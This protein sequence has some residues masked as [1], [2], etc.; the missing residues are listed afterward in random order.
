ME[1]MPARALDINITPPPSATLGNVHLFTI[2]VSLPPPDL[3]PIERIDLEIY[4]A[5]DQ[6]YKIV[7][8]NLP[9]TN[10]GTASYSGT[11][12]L[13]VTTNTSNLQHFVGPTNVAWQGRSYTFTPTPG[14]GYGNSSMTASITYGVTWTSPSTWSAAPTG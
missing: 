6:G 11:G 7:L 9:L 12:T 4:N 13:N 2:T 1:P 5:A 3:L 8:P 10:G 14:L